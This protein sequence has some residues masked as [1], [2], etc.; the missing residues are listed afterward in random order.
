MAHNYKL[1]PVLDDRTNYIDSCKEL[2]VRVEFTESLEEKK[3]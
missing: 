3:P 1:S 2:D